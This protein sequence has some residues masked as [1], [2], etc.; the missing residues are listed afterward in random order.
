MKTRTLPFL[1][2]AGVGTLVFAPS[3]AEAADREPSQGHHKGGFL[4]LSPAGVSAPIAG[5]DDVEEAFKP[6]YRFALGGGYMLPV[7]PLM[8]TLGASYEVTPL[9]W[10][11]DDIERED[12]KL[13]MHRLLADVRIG[14]T[15]VDDKLFVY[16]RFAPGLGIF[17]LGG[18]AAE[19]FDADDNETGF[20]AAVAVGGQ[21]MVWKKLYVGTEF[22]PA[23]HVIDG[24]EIHFFD[25]SL[26]AG[27][28]F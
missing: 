20:A 14:G 26:F 6:G 7:G 9:M 27:W 1:L 22:G 15:L 21:Y 13:D 11:D 23:F 3:R 12:L 24:D 19:E 17:V 4:Y 10:D 8:L 18:E 5:D 25:W 2:L 28:N 16:G